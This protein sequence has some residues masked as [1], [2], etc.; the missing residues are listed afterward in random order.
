MVPLIYSPCG[1]YDAMNTHGHTHAWTHTHTHKRTHTHT[2]T[3]ARTHARTPAAV[4]ADACALSYDVCGRV[5]DC[6]DLL[7]LLRR[8]SHLT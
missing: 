3:H 8:T 1:L 7:A 2:H 6:V 5:F 4:S